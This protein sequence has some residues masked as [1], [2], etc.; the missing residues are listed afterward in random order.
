MAIRTFWIED[1]ELHFGT[2]GG[3]TYDSDPEGEWAETELKAANLLTVAAGARPGRRPRAGRCQHVGMTSGPSDAIVWING[4]MADPATATVSWADH[5]ITVGDGVFE[6][7]KIDHG[8]PFALSRHLRAVP[9]A[10][11]RCSA[12]TSP[13]RPGLRDAAAG[14]VS[15]VGRSPGGV[16]ASR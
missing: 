2:G 13:T 6:T 14:R 10:R 9:V 4:E 11:P 16:C 8:R 1:D 12:S 3:I 5:G 15:G 7:I